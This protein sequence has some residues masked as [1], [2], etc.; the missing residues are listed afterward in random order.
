MEY[1]HILLSADRVGCPILFSVYSNNAKN[2]TAQTQINK[3]SCMES[4]NA[5]VNSKL[6][7]HDKHSWT[8]SF[9]IISFF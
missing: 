6:G 9:I 5:T 2:P 3:L 8:V 7:T 1:S 4:C